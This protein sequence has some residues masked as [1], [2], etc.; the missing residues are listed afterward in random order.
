MNCVGCFFF[1]F[2]F[3]FILFFVLFRNIHFFIHA[4]PFLAFLKKIVK[5]KLFI[6]MTDKVYALQK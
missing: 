6:K 3:I 4:N 2:F 5:K 1:F